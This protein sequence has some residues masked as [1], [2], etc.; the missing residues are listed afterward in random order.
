M[1]RLRKG[2]EEDSIMKSRNQTTRPA[3]FSIASP[4]LLTL[5]LL[6]ILPAAADFPQPTQP[7]NMVNISSQSPAP[8]GGFASNTTGG[9][10]TVVNINTTSQNPHWKAYVGNI[11]G[12]LAL[13]DGASNA[14]YDWNISSMEGEIYATR[15]STVVDWNSIVCAD[16][17]HISAEEDSLNF[18]SGNEDSIINTFNKKSHAAFYAGLTSLP[19]DSCNSTNLYV[20]GDASSDF[21]ELLLYD[22]SYIVYTSLL[23]NRITGFDGNEYDFQM[24]L[25]DS[26]LEGSQAPETYYFYVELI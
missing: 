6:S 12:R 16:E 15:K 20:N 23:E 24:I 5:L 4:L 1:D 11:S 25:P 8:T 18:S 3:V 21:E 9:T 19:A 26:G 14:I 17:T 22:G 7:D 13:Q 2:A 10:I